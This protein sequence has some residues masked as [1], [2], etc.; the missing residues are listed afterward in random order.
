MIARVMFSWLKYFDFW[1]A[2]TPG[3][4]DAASGTFV[5]SALSGGGLTLNQHFTLFDGVGGKQSAYDMKTTT[6]LVVNSAVVPPI[7]TVP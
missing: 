4:V 7:A 3:A 6:N 1:L 2:K 5:C